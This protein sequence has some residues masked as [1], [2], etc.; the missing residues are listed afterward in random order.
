MSYARAGHPMLVKMGRD[1]AQPENIACCGVALGLIP[2]T[3][4]F[5]ELIE[6][7]SIPLKQG[8]RFL[9]Y[10]DGLIDASDP[11]KDTYGFHRLSQLLAG[12]KDSDAEALIAVIM[13]DIKSFTRGAPY[14]D[15][16]TILALQVT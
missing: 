12:D 10:T 14:H 9:I 3:E 11:Q 13:A 7:V 4:K 1:G 6:E 16:L 2:E 8:D 5:G 15:D